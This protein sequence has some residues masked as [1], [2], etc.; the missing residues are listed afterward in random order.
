M[1]VEDLAAKTSLDVHLLRAFLRGQGAAS[2][3]KL[4]RVASALGIDAFALYEGK[5]LERALVALPRHAAREDFKH[6]DLPLLQSALE[7][8][9]ALLEVSRLLGKSCLR[10][11]FIASPPGA[12]PAEDG[13]HAA[14]VVRRVLGRRTEPLV[15]L[16]FM[17]AERFCVPVL[18]VSLATTSLQAAAVRSKSTHSAA[19]LLNDSLSCGPSAKG[20]Q[21][22]L[23][24]RVSMAHELCHILFDEPKGGVI[25][26]VLDDVPTK[27]GNRPPIEQRAG[28]FAAELLIPS[29]GLQERHGDPREIDTPSKADDLVDD[30]RFHFRTPAEVA[31]NHLYNH[32]YVAR[33]QDFRESLLKRAQERDVDFPPQESSDRTDVWRSILEERVREANEAGHIVDGTARAILGVEPGEL[34]PWEDRPW[35]GPWGA[36]EVPSRCECGV[37]L[38]A[39]R[40]TESSRGRRWKTRSR[41]R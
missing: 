4:D 9:T 40:P 13:Y 14:R 25:E 7:C 16:P 26:V 35:I 37:R 31:V 10:E 6:T 27:A 8:A 1:S 21:A 30:V 39:L 22:W 20:K 12:D 41:F 23:V 19:I 2:T 18:T 3:A 17:L 34:L 28:A 5:D 33:A 32:A 15:G 24:S 11:Q 36:R 38:S 29:L